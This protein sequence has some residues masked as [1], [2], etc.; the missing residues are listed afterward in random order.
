LPLLEA[1]LELNFRNNVEQSTIALEFQKHPRKFTPAGFVLL[2]EAS[3]VTREQIGE[4][5]N[6]FIV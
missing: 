4:L 5:R 2:A 1:P 3:K 6:F